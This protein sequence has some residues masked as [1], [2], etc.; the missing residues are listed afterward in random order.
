VEEGLQEWLKVW[1]QI[2]CSDEIRK[3]MDCWLKCI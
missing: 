3:L 2:F 1:L